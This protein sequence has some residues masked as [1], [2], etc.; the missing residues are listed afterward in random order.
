MRALGNRSHLRWALPPFLY[1][2]PQEELMA[3]VNA[4][5]CMYSYVC[6][7]KLVGRLTYR[8]R[9]SLHNSRAEARFGGRVKT[10]AEVG[11]GGGGKERG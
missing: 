3:N 2:I 7:R 9:P 1:I 11:W 5:Q 6:N 10:T 4:E 8:T